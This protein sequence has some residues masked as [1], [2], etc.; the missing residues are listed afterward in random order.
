MPVEWQTIW[1]PHLIIALSPKLWQKKDLQGVQIINITLIPGFAMMIDV[2]KILKGFVRGWMTWE[3]EKAHSSIS[4]RFCKVSGGSLD[5]GRF[6][7]LPRRPNI[8]LIQIHM[9]PC[10]LPE[11]LWMR[12]CAFHRN[13]R[14]WRR[15]PRHIS[16]GSCPSLIVD[17]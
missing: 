13:R 17:L 4:E 11:H 10:L 5:C 1:K 15:L 8:P 16:H 12:I 3:G 7:K 2:H 14:M 9:I 6:W